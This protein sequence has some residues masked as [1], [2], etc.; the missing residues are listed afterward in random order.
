ML[1]PLQKRRNDFLPE[2]VH[3]SERFKTA[4]HW[5]GPV[6]EC[7][8]FEEIKAYHIVFYRKFREMDGKGVAISDQSNEV[9]PIK[10]KKNEPLYATEPWRGCICGSKHKPLSRIPTHK[11]KKFNEAY[12]LPV[13][14]SDLDAV[15]DALIRLL[16]PPLNGGAG[17]KSLQAPG[18]P[19][20]DEAVLEK[21][22]AGAL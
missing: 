14:S 15:E 4:D 13:P 22:S 10:R 18:D 19:K 11:D 20:H 8:V 3:L 1:P 2:R 21:L 17:N 6:R 16:K 5:K 7:E 9:T 12:M